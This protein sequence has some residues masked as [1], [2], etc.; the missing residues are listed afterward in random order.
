MAECIQCRTKYYIDGT[1]GTLR[2]C[3]QECLRLLA[4]ETVGPGFA[5][6]LNEVFQS[7]DAHATECKRLHAALIKHARHLAPCPQL[8]TLAPSRCTCGLRESLVRET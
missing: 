2:F 5:G 1:G 6:D 4:A 8:G 3:S 7:R